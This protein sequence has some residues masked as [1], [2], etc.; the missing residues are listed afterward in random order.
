[1]VVLRIADYKDVREARECV[2]DLA[3]AA[4]I[5]DPSAVA[6]TTGELGNNCVEHGAS[7][8]ALL[9]ISCGRGRMTLRFENR[10]EQ[11]PSWHTHKPVAI[12]EFRVGGYGMQIVR[13]I[14]SDLSHGWTDGRAV[15]RA[16]FT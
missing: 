11:S 2:R 9:W 7:S 14:A 3:Y 8:P 4:G 6:L 1:M 13:A 10:C 16:E 15:V 5:G 12:E